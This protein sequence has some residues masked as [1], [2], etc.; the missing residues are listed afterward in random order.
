MPTT[1]H[2]T[3]AIYARFSTDLQK[4]SSIDDQV[5]A[6]EALAKREGYKVVGIFTDRA[7]SGSSLFDRKGADDLMDAVKAREF[8]VVICE[9]QS[10]LARDAADIHF[11]WKRLNHAQ[12]V[13]HSI[14][15]GIA[16]SMK[17]GM[18]GIMDA[19]FL[20]SLSAQVKRGLDGRARLGL[21]PGQVTYGYRPVAGGKPGEIEIDPVKA[22]IVRRIFN[23][24]VNEVSP[25]EIAVGLTRDGVPTPR[26]R[27]GDV[28]GHQAFLGGGDGGIISN[29]LYIGE[30]IWGKQFVVADPDTGSKSKRTRPKGD[31]IVTAA[32]HLRII[33]QQVWDAAQRL[34]TNRATRHGPGGLTIRPTL[35]RNR[36]HLL[37]GLLR[38]GTCNGKMIFANV[39]RGKRYVR[40]AAAQMKTDCSHQKSYDIDK[41]KKLVLDNLCT[42]FDDPA[43]LARQEIAYNSQFAKEEKGHGGGERA[44]IEKQIARLKLQMARIADVIMDGDDIDLAEFKAKLK[45]K[46]RERVGLAER[47]RHLGG[48]N[49]ILLPNAFGAYVQNVKKMRRRL[50]DEADADATRAAFRTVMDCIVVQPTRRGDDYVVDAFGRL[51]AGN[52]N[53][54]PAARSVQKIVAAEGFTACVGN[55]K[56]ALPFRSRPKPS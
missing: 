29:R 26:L 25:R 41:L 20:K 47:L 53:V 21:R 8:D 10:R 42:D 28:W 2:K 17:I 37:S 16:D 12:V 45:A 22:K 32:P 44:A 36:E 11:L 55:G 15:D 39:S 3:A 13:L 9:S 46:E 35:V 19:E 1:K 23:E 30:S 27:G 31:W 48:D 5:H 49:V 24:Y 7:K 14:S 18:R 6:C 33:D 38:C 40:C 34:R 54:R 56:T 52:V 4:D 50:V 51:N 43:W